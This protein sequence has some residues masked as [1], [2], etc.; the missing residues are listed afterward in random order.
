[1]K[2]LK[3]AL[4]AA[5]LS[6]ALAG[7][8]SDHKKDVVRTIKITIDQALDER[9][10]VREMYIQLDEKT[11][12]N[13]RAKVYVARVKYRKSLYLIQGTYKEWESFFLMDNHVPNGYETTA[14]SIS[15]FIN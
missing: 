13:E 5:F 7:Y 6:L 11:F 12:L 14:G 4:I 10:L 1:M 2:T 15:R 3:F 8:S 9:G